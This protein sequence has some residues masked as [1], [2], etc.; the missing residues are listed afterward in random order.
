VSPIVPQPGVIDCAAC[1]GIFLYSRLQG[2]L[3]LPHSANVHSGISERA[4]KQTIELVDME[5]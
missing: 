5:K 3:I 2:N 4:N 1:L